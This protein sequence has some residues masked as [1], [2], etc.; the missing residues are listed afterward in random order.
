MILTPMSLLDENIHKR[1]I[2][3]KVVLEAHRPFDP[4]FLKR[5]KHELMIEYTYNSNAIEGST[6]TLNETRLVLEE[7]LTI[8]SKPIQDSLGAKNHPYAINFIEKLV[9]ENTPLTE[10][11][12]LKLHSLILHDIGD[13]AGVYRKVGVRIAGATFSPPKSAEIPILM[14][15]LLKWLEKNLEEYSPIEQAALFHH[16]FVHIHPFSDG[17][18][19]TARLLMNAILMKNGYPFIINIT[20]KERTKYLDSLQEADLGNYKPFINYIAR[21]AENAL[22]IY[23]N[24]LEEPKIITLTQASK[25]TS[26]SVNYLG[27]LA[28]KG[29]IGAFKENNRWYIREQEIINYKK[30]MKHKQLKRESIR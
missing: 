12:V 27:L 20:Q 17:N 19:R 14:N 28:R 23:L 15:E 4:I 7:G 3:K 11:S 21:S 25:L 10:E 6:L 5:L 2:E 30:E 13:Y 8:G 16:K 18:G 9:Y 29:R 26:Y 1:I 24:A 22:D